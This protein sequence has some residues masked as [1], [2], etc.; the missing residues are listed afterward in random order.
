MMD[1]KHNSIGHETYAGDVRAIGATGLALG[2][3]IAIV[4]ALV[5]GIFEYLAHH[6]IVIMPAN[7]MAETDRQQFPP[8]PRIEEHPS[9]EL[10]EL[11][12][13][14]DHILSTYGWTDKKDGVVRIPID[15]A[16]E[17]QLERG[18][19]IRKEAPKK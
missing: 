18:F 2:I 19:P 4:L 6:R 16:M 11:H 15:R 3:G 14:E 7:P 17:L 5:Y 9:I 10:Q 12:S 13:Q 8:A 1:S